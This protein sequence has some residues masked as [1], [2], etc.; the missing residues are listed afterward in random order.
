MAR[1][2]SVVKEIVGPHQACGIKGRNIVTN[3]HI[4]RSVLECSDSLD[5]AVAMLQIDLGKAFDKV[6]HELL[7]MILDHINVGKMITDGVRM[8]C[9]DCSTSLVINKSVGA[10][11]KVSRSVCHGCPIS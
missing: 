10:P 7:L 6:S 11:V 1:L 9:R 2:Q 4:A 3:T 8:A 5:Q